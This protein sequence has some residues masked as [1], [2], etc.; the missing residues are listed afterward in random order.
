MISNFNVPFTPNLS[1][2]NLNYQAAF[3]LLDLA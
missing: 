2:K 3:F 1:E